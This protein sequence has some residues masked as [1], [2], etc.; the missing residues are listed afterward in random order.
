MQ[1]RFHAAGFIVL[2]LNILPPCSAAWAQ[3][4]PSASPFAP[5][6]LKRPVFDTET[7]VYP[8]GDAE[9]KAAAT[10]VA[11][12]DGRAVTLGDVG[13]AVR[14]LPANVAALPFADLYPGV[15]AQL[16]RQEALV[17]RAV[18]RGL[19]EDPA[20][21][22]QMRAASEQVLADEQLRR[23]I[24]GQIT[25]EMLLDRYDKA[26]VGKPGPTE[27]RLRVIKVATEQEAMGL[28]GALKAG[29]DFATLAKQWS[30][31]PT[32]Q[33]G[34]DAGYT[35]RERL[36][37]EVGPVA[38]SMSPGQFTAYPVRG[39]DCWFVLKVEDRRTTPVRP[40][41]EMREEIRQVLLREGVADVVAAAL[42]DVTVREYDVTGKEADGSVGGAG[43]RAER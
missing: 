26:I 42:R 18:R 16:V 41:S 30:R 32:A 2:V 9:A 21:R 22:R 35:T 25:E 1:S 7:T 34:G 6:D 11:E 10:V 37:V 38:F 4:D 3:A 12:V 20:V 27:V 36:T 8:P 31:D 5:G 24:S 15:L 40:F 29:A 43:A 28:I 19:D 33:A 13:D 23:E 17:I 39:T 14:R